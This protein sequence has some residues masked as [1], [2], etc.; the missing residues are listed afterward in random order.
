MVSA[1]FYK[2]SSI[3]HL[4]SPQEGSV[5]ESSSTY[6]AKHLTGTTCMNRWVW[7]ATTTR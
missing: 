3:R 2:I 4:R 7:R 5:N 6:P 1:A